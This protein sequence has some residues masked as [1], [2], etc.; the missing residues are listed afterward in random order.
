VTIITC[1]A[2]SE[3]S[4]LFFDPDR[5]LSCPWPEF[6]AVFAE[7]NIHFRESVE[8]NQFGL[9]V[10]CRE[11]LNIQSFLDKQNIPL[12]RRILL[13]FEP[14]SV[15]P[16]PFSAMAKEKYGSI[17]FASHSDGTGYVNGFGFPLDSYLMGDKYCLTASSH[18]TKRI[19]LVQANKFSSIDGE[20]YSLRRSLIS[21]LIKNSIPI[22]VYGQGWKDGLFSNYSK[23]VS[24]ERNRYLAQQNFH[25]NFLRSRGS[26]TNLSTRTFL[27]GVPVRNKIEL[28]EKYRYVISVENDRDWQSEKIFDPLA[29][30]CVTFYVGPQSE[31]TD[32]HPEGLIHLAADTDSA[33]QSII[34]A[35]D[36]DSHP[37]PEVISSRAKKI[38]KKNEKARVFRQLA[39]QI[40][41]QITGG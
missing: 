11:H 10:V 31:F 9:A 36:F 5:R 29:A 25:E 23:A 39:E 24:A 15:D 22:D 14:K 13:V 19:A 2:P 20:Q 38:F 37:S 21:A 32:A 40:C 1:A 30:G 3:I 35:F 26:W 41:D 16:F 8:G 18:R 4:A 12:S 27:P 33:A 7:R 34:R 28:F 6:S 17:F